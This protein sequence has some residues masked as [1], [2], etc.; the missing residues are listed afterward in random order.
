VFVVSGSPIQN[1]LEYAV[2]SNFFG[3]G[4]NLPDYSSKIFTADS[5][6]FTGSCGNID[7]KSLTV[8]QQGISCPWQNK[9]FFVIQN[10]KDAG[11]LY[12]IYNDLLCQ[13]YKQDFWRRENLISDYDI[14]SLETEN[15]CNRWIAKGF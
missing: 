14:E 15:F 3:R 5:F 12:K 6:I 4:G 10:Q 13:R 1:Y 8:V 2:F 9:N 7:K 11:T